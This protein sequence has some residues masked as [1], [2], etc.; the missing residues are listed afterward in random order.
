LST[1]TGRPRRTVMRALATLRD[2]KILLKRGVSGGYAEWRFNK[3]FDAWLTGAKSGTGRRSSSGARSGTGTGAKS[4]A[5]TGAKSGTPSKKKKRKNKETAE[6]KGPPDRLFSAWKEQP[7]LDTE[8]DKLTKP[9][10]TAVN[11]K[12]RS[13]YTEADLMDVILNYDRLVAVEAAPGFGDWCFRRLMEDNE[14]FDNL[15]N[16]KWLGLRKKTE[17]RPAWKPGSREEER[18]R[19]AAEG[20][21]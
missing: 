8:T 1:A 11:K 6:R 18:R 21:R 9:G 3:D 4:G 19:L 13:G 10:R 12:I 2:S 5:G 17:D 7:N 16:P 20:N 15:R 14:W